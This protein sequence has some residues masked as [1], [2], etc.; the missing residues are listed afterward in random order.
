MNVD[1][2]SVCPQNFTFSYVKW[3]KCILFYDLQMS[4][5]YSFK[6]LIGHIFP[7]QIS[8]M[9]ISV[10]IRNLKKNGHFIIGILFKDNDM[11]KSECDHLKV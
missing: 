6:Q 8:K 2:F 1:S 5:L 9:D 3:F 4:Y 11:N 10:D 7:V